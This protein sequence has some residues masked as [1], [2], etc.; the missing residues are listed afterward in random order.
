MFIDAL[1]RT[2]KLLSI[3]G[4]HRK[5]AIIKVIDGAEKV[6]VM[7]VDQDEWSVDQTCDLD[8]SWGLIN[9]GSVT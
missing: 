9:P 6:I 1:R 2:F 5:G 4:L 8:T 7:V 3:T